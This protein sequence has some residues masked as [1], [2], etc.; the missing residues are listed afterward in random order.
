M[1]IRDWYDLRSMMHV[2]PPSMLALVR[3]CPVCE[4]ATRHESGCTYEGLS[5]AAAWRKYKADLKKDLLYD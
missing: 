2:L 4:M 3:T 5:M 1:G